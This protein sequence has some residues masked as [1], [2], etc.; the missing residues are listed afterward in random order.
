MAELSRA[1]T[2][3]VWR[4]LISAARWVLVRYSLKVENSG[5]FAR[6]LVMLWAV[7]VAER[8]NRRRRRERK[9]NVD[10]AIVVDVAAEQERTTGGV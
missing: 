9:E 2:V 5:C 1:R 3:M 10:A 6:I 7:V 8:V 4:L